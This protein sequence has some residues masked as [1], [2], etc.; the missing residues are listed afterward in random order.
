[1]YMD[2]EE[3][4]RGTVIKVLFQ[5]AE[6]GYTVLRLQC[7]DGETVT[8]VGVIPMTVVGERLMITGRWGSHPSHG[9]QF[10]AEFLE[11]LMPETE[12]EI[13]RLSLV[14]RPEGD[15]TQNGRANRRHFW[16]AFSRHPRAGARAAL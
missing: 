16:A 2:R 1:M 3:I 11:R 5:N 13:S 14:P 9:R 12:Q 15:W 10:E 8:V 7:E 4:L 6:N